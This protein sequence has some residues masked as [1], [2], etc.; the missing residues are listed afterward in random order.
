M[1]TKS[2]LLVAVIAIV[3]AAAAIF[4]LVILLPEAPGEGGSIADTPSAAPVEVAEKRLYAVADDHRYVDLIEVDLKSGTAFLQKEDQANYSSTWSKPRVRNFTVQLGKDQDGNEQIT[5]VGWSTGVVKNGQLHF[6]A[7]T[8]WLVEKRL[9][10]TSW[11]SFNEW[12]A[13]P[14]FPSFC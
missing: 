11:K 6:D 14:K 2:R 4:T 12:H 7:K 9:C 10:E 8:K 3:I 5:F 1:S 13:K